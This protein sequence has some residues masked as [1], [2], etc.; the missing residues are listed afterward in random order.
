MASLFERLTPGKAAASPAPPVPS[1]PFS[2]T[3]DSLLD[4]AAQLDSDGGMPGRDSE[5]RAGNTIAA[6]C[7]FLA[8]GHTPRSGA[9]RSHVSRMVGFLAGLAGLSQQRRQLVDIVLAHASRGETFPGDWLKLAAKP[10]GHWKEIEKAVP[11][12]SKPVK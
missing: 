6:L 11:Q 7:A 3:E 5:E 1:V 8:H 4:L 2:T 10:G 12:A 9:F